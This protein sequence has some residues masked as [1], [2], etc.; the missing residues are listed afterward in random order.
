M[1]E[2]DTLWIAD[3]AEQPFGRFGCEVCGR[4]GCKITAKDDWYN[5]EGEAW[6]QKCYDWNEEGE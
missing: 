3:L 5:I 1:E 2:D 6:C 4:C